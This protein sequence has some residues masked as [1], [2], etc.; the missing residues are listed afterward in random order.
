MLLSLRWAVS[1]PDHKYA[2]H[3]LTLSEN[4]ARMFEPESRRELARYSVD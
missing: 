2:R 3:K 1:P 4:V